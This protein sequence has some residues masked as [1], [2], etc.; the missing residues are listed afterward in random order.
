MTRLHGRRAY[1]SSC[2]YDTPHGRPRQV[3]DEVHRWLRR[4]PSLFSHPLRYPDGR[5]PT[6]KD[7]TISSPVGWRSLRLGT[8]ARQNGLGGNHGAEALKKKG[9]ATFF[10]GKGTLDQPNGSGPR[11]RTYVNA[12]GFS[13]GPYGGKKYFSPTATPPQRRPRRR[14]ARSP[15]RRNLQVC[16]RANAKGKPFFFMLS[17]YSVH[18]PLIGRPD[19]VEKYKKRAARKTGAEFG[20]EELVWQ[21]TRGHARSAF[22]KNMP[23]TLPWWKRWTSPSDEC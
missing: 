17:F 7:A 18:T 5:H 10:A 9:Y 13:K 1:N 15:R 19:L 21:R 22:F 16:R 20:N 3:G 23:S 2:F 6:R 8:P 11:N 12:G 4:R 14:T